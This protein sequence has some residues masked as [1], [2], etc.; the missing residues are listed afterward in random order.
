[1]TRDWNVP[2]NE[3]AHGHA[4]TH[5]RHSWDSANNRHP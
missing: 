3:N 1:V 4:T 2:K 5:R